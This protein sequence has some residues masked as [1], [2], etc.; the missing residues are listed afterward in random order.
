MNIRFDGSFAEKES[1]ACVVLALSG[2]TVDQRRAPLG[3]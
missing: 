2:V 3:G 1:F